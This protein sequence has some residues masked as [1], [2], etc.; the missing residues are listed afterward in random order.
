MN[1]LCNINLLQNELQNAVLQPLGTAPLSPKEGQ[2]YYNST[3]KLIYRY[4]GTQW[5]AVGVVYVQDSSTGAVITGLDAS[6]N[7]ATTNVIGLTLTGY[8]PVEGGYIV[9]GMTM[10][11]ALQAMDTAIKNAV[12]GGGEV[13]QNA[14]SN[15]LIKAQSAAETAVAGASADV[16][17]QATAKTDT[18]TMATG[19]KWVDINGAGKQINIGHSLSGVV[20]GPVGDGTHIPKLTVDAAGHVTA[21]E[22]IEVDIADYTVVKLAQAGDGYIAS[23]QLQKDGAGVGAVINIPKDYLVK[24]AEIKTSTGTGDPS[25]F[26]AGTKYIDFTINTYDTE[27]GSGTESHI[28]LNVQDLVGINKITMNGEEND[29]PAFYAPIDSGTAGQYLVSGGANAAPTW[30]TLPSGLKKYVVQNTALTASGGAFTWSIPAAT[31]GVNA[32]MSVTVYDVVNDGAM[33][34]ADVAIGASGNVSITINDTAGV[35]TLTAN[36]YQAVIIG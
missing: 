17:L 13:N 6:G 8:T 19:N 12:A 31:H 27:A 11:E 3:D 21:M 15:I 22:N 24:S 18:F 28:Y 5:G 7:V 34:M 2:F 30:Q 29:N 1:I 23:Y 20:A 4:D 25:G 26:P 9:A 10:Q 35:G 36:A 32:P 33:V 16:T 14:W